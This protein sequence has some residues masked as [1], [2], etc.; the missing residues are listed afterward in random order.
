MTGLDKAQQVRRLIQS[1]FLRLRAERLPAEL[2]GRLY[3]QFLGPEERKAAGVYYTPAPI[4]DAIVQRTLGPLCQGRTPAALESLRIL[5]PACGSGCFLL[6]AYQYL[7]NWHLQWYTANDP[8]AHATGDAPALRPSG[9][10]TWRLT[11]RVRLSLLECLHGVDIDAQAVEVTRLSLL[12]KL[13]EGE[14][15]PREEP[16]LEHTLRC[17]NTLREEPE[18]ASG[19]ASGEA[20]GFDVVLGNPP[21]LNI[22][23]LQ[24]TAPAE[25]RYYKERYAS[26]ARGS[27]DLYAVFVERGLSLLR[28]GGRLGYI[29]PSRF[30][31]TDYGEPLR[32][33]LSERRVVREIIDFQHAQL[34]SAA[35]TY[36]ALL[37][38]SAEPA[39]HFT[40]RTVSSI[41]ALSEAAPSTRRLRS[42]SLTAAPWRFGSETTTALLDRLQA[43]STPLLELP[44]RMTRG[45]STG[46]DEVF[47]LVRSGSQL[48]T[49]EGR[50]VDVEEALLRTP[51]YATDYSRY[52]FQPAAS[53]RVLFPY[54]VGP[55]GYTLLDEERLRGEFPKAHAYLTSRREE[56]EQRKQYAAWYGFSAPRGLEL[57]DAAQLLVPLLAERGSATELPPG[58]REY[59][60]MASG[61]FSL[62]LPPSSPLSPRFL[63]GLLNSKLLFWCLRQLCL[64]NVFRGGWLPCTQQYVGKLPI[65]RLD[66]T[67]QEDA[68]AHD[69]IVHAVGTR[70]ELQ[71][72][73]RQTRT[74]PELNRLHAGI[75]AVEQQLDAC[76]YA[77]Y[78]LTAEDIALLEGTPAGGIPL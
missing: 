55:E 53:E 9:D 61:G 48:R 67:R 40:Y 50:A 58:R 36:T 4:V 37:F 71:E 13:F 62:S 72:A 38:L 65:R 60:L 32:R 27:Y 5:D 3:E 35:T 24:E 10:G 59:C 29:L 42:E 49:R 69:E 30:F 41:K 70:L 51:L 17:G 7:L 56:L 1:E 16:R 52:R 57:H 19:E 75:V 23:T 44:T 46:N 26:A 11:H 68:R 78:G 43:Q 21:Y 33:L 8:A 77:L 31:S 47:I 6:G 63:L 74:S 76:V 14:S 39:E 45:T 25:A 34:F 18:A 64:G 15:E 73:L 28:P 12:L 54:E 22:R 66:L 20:P 2:L